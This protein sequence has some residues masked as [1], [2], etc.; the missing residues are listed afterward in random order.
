MVM[1]WRGEDGGWMELVPFI[2]PSIIIIII[3]NHFIHFS[4]ITSD[5]VME[6]SGKD[7]GGMEEW[8]PYHPTNLPSIHPSL[9]HE[10]DKLKRD[11]DESD[12]HWRRWVSHGEW[13]A[14]MIAAGKS[15]IAGSFNENTTII[16]LRLKRQYIA[17]FICLVHSFT[18]L[19]SIFPTILY[20]F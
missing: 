15:W 5:M 12:S 11:P 17:S 1:K 8:E 19:P 18:V 6:W 14:V 13:R 20:N 9:T 16:L 2:H 4:Q 10:Q 7:G 3:I